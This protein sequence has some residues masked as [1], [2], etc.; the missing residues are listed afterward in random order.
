MVPYFSERWDRM[1]IERWDRMLMEG[2]VR[3]LIPGTLLVVLLSCALPGCAPAPQDV[4]GVPGSI[5]TAS[6]LPSWNDGA[7]KQ[8]IIE[9][10]TAVTAVGSADFVPLAERIAT[11]DNDGTLWVEQ[12]IY[13]QIAF[14]LDRIRELAPQHPEWQSTE[15]FKSL[16]E[17][18]M[19]GVAA[20]GEQGLVQILLAGH[21]GMTTD[22][23]VGIVESWI[24]TARQPRFDRLY[25]EL[26]YLPMVELIAY[27]Q[28]NGFKTYIVSGGGIEFMRPWTE[29]V[30]NIPP[31]QV[32]G[33]SIKT[34]FE[35]RDGSPVLV[36]QPEVFFVDDK[37]GKA[38]GIQK[39]IGRRPIASFGN[40][41]ADIPMLQWTL[42]GEGR[43]LAML[44]HHTDAER[45]YAYDRD[46][47][48]GTLARGL[49]DAA[50]GGWSVIDTK[51]DW[52]RFFAFEQ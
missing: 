29:Q 18:D 4:G 27:L 43:R 36:R 51:S 31:E 7:A 17:G 15:P 9:F 28:A 23:F 40:A 34:T 5:S 25:T 32:I 37:E 30:Y 8:A 41:D 16:L 42:A 20:A 24:S 47:H 44:V 2:P 19:E 10:V 13:A 21:T 1:L 3:R 35:M 45:E 14:G 6:P 50:G 39:F 46:S 12:P 11:F 49:D 48:I 52:A 38:I 33:S 22:E 26:A